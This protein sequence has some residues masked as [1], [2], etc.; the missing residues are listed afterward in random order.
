MSGARPEGTTGGKKHAWPVKKYCF[1]S[2]KSGRGSEYFGGQEGQVGHEVTTGVNKVK[3]RGIPLAVAPRKAIEET[4][5]LVGRNKGRP[6]AVEPPIR[7][8]QVVGRRIGWQY[9]RISSW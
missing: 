1:P 9:N 7:P 2:P 3:T 6:W 5:K 4:T 8:P